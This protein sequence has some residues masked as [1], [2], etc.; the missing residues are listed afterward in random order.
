LDRRGLRA[1]HAVAA[2]RHEERVAQ[3]RRGVVHRRVE[4]LEVV[5]RVLDLGALGD[6]VAHAEEDLLDLAADLRYRVL[7][8]AGVGIARPSGAPR[9][10]A[11]RWA[12]RSASAAPMAFRAA[13]AAAPAGPRSS[14][15]RRP[16]P[17]ST[18]LSG[19]RRP[20]CRTRASSSACRSPAART[21]ARAASR[22]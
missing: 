11:W 15:G 18:P 19:L 17:E 9:S 8:A 12:E 2:P 22:S 13:F 5:P 1:Q 16:I 10:A 7:R 4:R 3:A 20:R 14:G 21:A 6:H